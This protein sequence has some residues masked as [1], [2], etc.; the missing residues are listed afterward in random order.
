METMHPFLLFLIRNY[1]YKFNCYIYRYL[2]LLFLFLFLLLLCNMTIQL[3]LVLFYFPP[4]PS[5]R[6]FHKVR[7]STSTVF[8][9][10]NAHPEITAHQKQ[11]FFKGGGKVH[12]TD[13]FWRVLEFVLLLLKIK[14][15]RRVFRQTRY[16]HSQCIQFFFVLS[17]RGYSANYCKGTCQGTMH[18]QQFHHSS[19]MQVSC[20]LTISRIVR[21]CLFLCRADIYFWQSFQESLTKSKAIAEL[22]L[23]ACCA[24]TRMAALNLLFYDGGMSGF[25]IEIH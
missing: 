13:G 6:R 8:V 16:V 20:H 14:R 5:M 11:W 22:S 19:I 12:K 15:P 7:T 3:D 24:P 21:E 4:P 10:I 18:T 1:Y 2:L 17:Y 9:E 23:S 25:S